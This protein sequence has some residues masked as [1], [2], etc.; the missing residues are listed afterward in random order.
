[1]GV[2]IVP[3][4]MKIKGVKKTESMTM[5]FTTIL[6]LACLLILFVLKYVLTL[7]LNVFEKSEFEFFENF[8]LLMSFIAVRSCSRM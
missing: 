8:G 5:V 6:L 4:F 3:I 7:F 1:M 2:V